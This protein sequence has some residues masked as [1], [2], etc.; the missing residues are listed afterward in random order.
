MGEPKHLLMLGGQ[1]L[2]DRAVS[3]LRP[4]VGRVVIAGGN[5]P[6][7]H[8]DSVPDVFPSGGPLA[9]IHA[10]LAAT[11]DKC[12]VVACDMPF[13]S[14]ALLTHMNETMGASLVAVPKVGPYFEPLHAVY[15][16]ECASEIAALFEE[17]TAAPGRTCAVKTRLPRVADLF[18]RVRVHVI[19]ED[20][21]REFG[22]PATIFFNINRPGD[23][24]AAVRALEI[25]P[26]P[27]ES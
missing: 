7:D 20:A 4:Y 2:L 10:A 21:I 5:A 18:S 16:P 14:P 27:L 17:V 11:S 3:R 13:F 15:R 1:T 22:D 6:P 26:E 12:A 24:E 8:P 25:L 23:Y 19:E 9:G